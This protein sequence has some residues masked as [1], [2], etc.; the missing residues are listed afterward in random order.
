MCYYLLNSI[1]LFIAF[2]FNSS[3]LNSC[4]ESSPPLHTLLLLRCHSQYGTFINFLFLFL[5]LFYFCALF[6]FSLRAAERA[7][8]V[9]SI[10]LIAGWYVVCFLVCLRYSS[11]FITTITIVITTYTTKCRYPMESDTSPN[12]HIHMYIHINIYVYIP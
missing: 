6:T 2:F 10:K 9:W 11:Y 4:R 7:S 1:F 3:P 8:E 12:T 5:F